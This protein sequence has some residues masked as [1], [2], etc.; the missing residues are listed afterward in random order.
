MFNVL[1]KFSLIPSQIFSFF[2]YTEIPNE[3]IYFFSKTKKT[4]K[5]KMT[6]SIKKLTELSKLKNCEFIM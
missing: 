5:G 3:T 1:V 2:C 6:E 4:W